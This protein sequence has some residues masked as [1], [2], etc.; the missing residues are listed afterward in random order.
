MLTPS[1]ASD[2]VAGIN[3]WGHHIRSTIRL[4]VPFVGAQLAQMAI[5]TTDV[6]MVGWLGTLELAA[7]VLASQ[8]FFIVFIFGTGFAAAVVP[9]VAHAVGRGDVTSVRRAVRMGI[10]VVLAYGILTAPILWFSRPILLILGQEPDVAQLAQDYLRVAQWGIF[11]ALA[12]MVLRSFLSGLER[13]SIILYVTIGMFL[14]NAVLN[15][16]LIFGNFGAPAW[17]LV[18]AAVASVCSSA[19]GCIAMIVYIDGR[20]ETRAYELFVRFWRADWGAIREN[21]ALGLPIS[22]TILA[23]TSLFAA[24]SLLIGTIGTRELAAHGIALQLASIAFMIP[25]G[26][27]QV[28][29]VRVGLAYGREDMVGVK[30]AAVAVLVVSLCFSACGSLLFAFMPRTL[31]LLF[32][33]I[34]NPDAQAVL[35]YA[36]SLI[37]I[38]GV[39]QLADGLQAV[40]AGLLRGLKDTKV[41][42]M[43]ALVAYW[44]IG[45]ACAWLF[46]F[47][48]GF[49]GPG[50][51]FGFVTG[52]GAA[53]ILL[54]GR[55]YLLVRRR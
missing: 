6:I 13:G 20:A 16:A 45:F 55:F 44:P 23:E 43:L 35:E 47:P 26:L 25:L 39:F 42:M 24:A 38:A 11:P 19:F 4:G 5:N 50:V 7:V 12:L 32:L 1:A 31:G 15:Y 48:L 53:A 18:G 49:G 14:A 29:T 40:G 30:R 54:C 22:F 9:M 28:A 8:M 36:A 27:A 3:S 10:W 41:P 52:L 17:G 34:R 51:W 2:A 46:A 21:I 37:V 33:D